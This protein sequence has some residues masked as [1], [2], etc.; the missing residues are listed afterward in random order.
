[1]SDFILEFNLSSY[2]QLDEY[3][4]LSCQAYNFG[5]DSDWFG[6][7][8]GGLYGSY[9]RI[10]GVCSHY[11]AVHA[12]VPRPRLPSETECH[13]ASL[14]FNMDSFIECM[15]Y[16][17]N[18]FGYIASGGAEFRDITCAKGLKRIS[19]CDILGRPNANPPQPYLKEYDTYFPEVRKYWE[20]KKGLINMIFEQH[21]VSKHRET[22]FVGGK[23]RMTPPLGFFES[24]G[25][26]P[27]NSSQSA[28]FWP[29]E[30]IIIKRDPK[31][32]KIDRTPQPV[33]GRVFL[34]SLV[35]E[36]QE[37]AE[38]TGEL[39]LLDAKRNIKLKVTELKKA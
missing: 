9:A 21:D 38:M 19:P 28:L 15:T 31:S 10:H 8:R 25:V 20:S 32:P 18:A 11:H 39:A 26:D 1:M 12:W 6:T 37:F 16:A 17:L 35:P 23:C 30:E 14:F 7:F 29:M 5:N 13:L 2:H 34:E 27:K 33:E 3:A 22:I 24:I 36:F 4:L